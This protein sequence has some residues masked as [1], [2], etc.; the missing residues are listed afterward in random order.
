MRSLRSGER[1]LLAQRKEAQSAIGVTE[2][3]LVELN[4]KRSESLAF[5]RET[6][7]VEKYKQ[8]ARELSKI[9]AEVA[10]LEQRREA[11][12]R[13]TELRRKVRATSQELGQLQTLVEEELEQLSQDEAGRFGEIRRH[14]ADVIA[15]VLDEQAVLSMTLN[16]KGGVEFRAEMMGPAGAVTSGDRGTSYRKLL[17][18]AFDLAILRSYLDVSFPRFV[19]LDGALEQLE[20]RTRGNLIEVFREYAGAGIQPIISLLSSDLPDGLGESPRT[21]STQDI[22]LTLHDAGDDGLLFKMPPW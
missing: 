9:Q 8:T 21:L 18:I 4:E 17:C 6:D 3:E 10:V 7:S 19:Y 15:A 11:A 5:L 20:P 13:L 1:S 16:K 12:S 14:F 22:V 2:A